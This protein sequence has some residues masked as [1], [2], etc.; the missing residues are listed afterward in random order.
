MKDMIKK[1][2]PSFIISWYHLV[3]AFLGALFY[4]FPSRKLKVIGVTG[5]NGKTTVVEMCRQVLDEA[6]FKVASLSSVKFKIKDRE[7]PNILKMTM[8]GRFKIQK[9]LRQAEDAGCEY[10]VLEVTSEGIRQHRHRFIDFNTAVFTN[11]TPEHVER[12]GSFEKYRKAK[13]KLFQACKN[14]HIINLDDKNAEYFLQFP[15]SKKIGYRINDGQAIIERSRTPLNLRLPGNFNLYNAAAAISVGLSHRISL[16]ICKKAVEMMESVPGRMELVV[17]EPFRVFV[18]YAHNPDALEKIYQAISGRK[19]CVLGSAGGGRDKWKRP[20]LGRIAS[21]YCDEIILT[22]EDPYDEN[23]EKILS[24]IKSGIP[25]TKYQISPYGRSPEGRLN[26]IIDRIEAI[27]KALS[28][29][30]PGDAV[31]VT[32]KGSEPWMCVA[33]GK[34]IPWSDKAIVLDGFDK[35]T[36]NAEQNRMH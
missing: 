33:G 3:L 7:W 2:F 16:E 23:P 21:K 32:G 1:F 25:N 30:K 17:K 19:I 8:P 12:H 11:I 24:E 26:T 15:A 28:L 29:A 14:I 20:E 13:G 10:A 9:F 5:T 18:D 4:G 31:I 27:K 35:L 36:I 34:K 6:G 22:N